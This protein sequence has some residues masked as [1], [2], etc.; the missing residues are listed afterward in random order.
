MSSGDESP[1][2]A[3]DEKHDEDMMDD[4]MGSPRGAMDEKHDEDMM[5]DDMGESMHKGGLPEGVRK[6]IIKPASSENWKKP[7]V[8]DLVTVHYVGTVE[9][10]GTEFF[11]SRKEDK[12]REINLGK[13]DVVKG[14]ELGIGTMCQ[15]EIAKFTLAPEFA[16]GDEGVLPEIPGKATVVYEIELVSWLS[17]EDLFGDEGVIKTVLKDGEGWKKPKEGDEIKI[18]ITVETLDGTVVDEKQNFE[19]T[20]GSGALGSVGKACDKAL[21]G[22]KRREQSS[23]KCSKDYVS[24]ERLQTGALLT[25]TLE[26][27]YEIADVSFAKDK[28]VM[29]KQIQEGS[30]YDKPKDGAKVKLFVGSATDGSVPIP[31]FTSK[32]LEFTAGNG[33]VCDALECAVSEMKKEE[34]AVLTISKVALAAEE[35]LGLKDIV[36]STVILAVEL[37]DYEKP[38][39]TWDMSSEEKIEFGKSRKEIGSSLFKK[40]RTHMALSCYKKVADTF[41]YI[42]N[43]TGDTKAKAAELK[44]VCELNKAACFVKLKEFQDAKKACKAVLKDDAQNLKALY[45]RAQAEYGLTNF[46][47]CVRDCKRI[48]ELDSK[49]TDARSLWRDAQAAQKLEDKK[50]QGLYSNMCKAL[51]KGPIP[52]PYVSKKAS[53]DEDEDMADVADDA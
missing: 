30:G 3:M 11:S 27:M 17:R 4:D 5:D 52:E 22:M 48:V 26:E 23:L 24:D 19:Y 39:A 8:G 20:V 9:S 35:Q 47:E 45:R 7:K 13:Q 51:G 10:D 29:K 46:L 53:D 42:D 1:R 2:G 38:K 32:T 15:G 25:I 49:N 12:P 43:F 28:S 34:K 31:G 14:V 41:N 33:E 18:A 6:E 16:F 37:T 44:K 36:T 21:L 40:G 50:S